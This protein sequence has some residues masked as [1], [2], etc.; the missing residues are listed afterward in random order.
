M[1]NYLP[2]RIT[3]I[4]GKVALAELQRTHLIVVILTFTVIALIIFIATTIVEM[5]TFLVGAAIVLLALLGI[6]SLTTAIG[7]SRLIKK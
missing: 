3:D 4:K 6:M 7:L 2:K 5:N 1:N